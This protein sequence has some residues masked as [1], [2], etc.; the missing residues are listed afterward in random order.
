MELRHLRYFL[1]VAEEQNVTRAAARLHVSQPPL[2]RQIQDLEAELGVELFE[3]RA[4]SIRLT[5]AGRVLLDEVRVLLR[6]LDEAVGKVRAVATGN[7][8]ELRV[9]YAPSP[10][11]GLLPGVLRAFQKTAPGVRVTL[12]DHSSPEMLTGL[13]EG[14][15]QAAFMMQPAKAAARGVTFEWLRTYPITLAVPP[16]HRFARRRAVAVADVIR[17][18]FV[19]YALKEYPDYHEFV[20]RSLGAAAKQLRVVEEC[21]SGMSLIAAVESGKGVAITSSILADTAGRRLRFV[22]L[23]PAPPPAVVGIA[24]RADGLSLLTRKFVESARGERLP[25]DS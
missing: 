1:A 21:D 7:A 17:E 11:V 10:T 13:R 3:R 24:Y 6:S 15:L 5:E 20:A 23:I 16:D 12:Q 19:A 25:P 14:R 22:P 2:T 8:G 9:G 18:P 4:K